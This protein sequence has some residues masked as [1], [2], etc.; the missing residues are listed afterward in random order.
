MGIG[1][2]YFLRKN[3][4]W[5]L[6]ITWAFGTLLINGKASTAGSDYN[7]PA[8]PS[9]PNCVSSQAAGNRFIEPFS[10]SWDTKAAF[11]KLR[12]IL[13]RRK[14]ATMVN[15]DDKAIRVE[16][17]TTVGFVDDGLF[18][19]DG[20]KKVIHVRSASR[21]GYWDFSKNRRRLET[22]RQEYQNANK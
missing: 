14:D 11:D 10:V 15:A 21:L 20:E 2:K 16:F 17:T 18:V 8:C 9:S 19:L 4:V 7:L 3:K 1:L 13:A 12:E 5:F 6:C 22:I